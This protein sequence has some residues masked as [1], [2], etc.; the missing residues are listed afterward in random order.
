VE[1][2]VDAQGYEQW[3]DLTFQ[4]DREGIIQLLTGAR[5]YQGPHAVVKELL[6]NAVDASR[7]ARALSR[8]SIPIRVEFSSAK[9]TLSISDGGIGMDRQ[10]I[11]EFL[12]RLGR[13]IYRSDLYQQR[14]MPKQRIDALSE[15]GIGFASCFLVSDHVVVETKQEGQDAYLLDLYDLLGFAAARK[16]RPPAA[17]TTV[18]LHLKESILN[19]I[20]RAVK[21]IGTTCPHMEIPI[22]VC[23]DGEETEVVAQPYCEEDNALLSPFFRSKVTDLVVEHHHFVLETDSV[24][25]CICL[26]CHRK[27][28]LVLP[29]Y[30]D[31]F[32]LAASDR[33]RISQLGF[34][35][36]EPNKLLEN[37]LSKFNVAA[38]RYDLDLRG[39]M[40]LEMDPSR[41]GV[42]GSNH[43]VEV[44]RRLDEYVVSYLC[45][46]H[47]K[48]WA[49]IT[50]ESRFI[51]YREFGH[52]FFTRVMDAIFFKAQKAAIRLADLMFDNM[53]LNTVSKSKGSCDLTWN[54]IRQL[55]APVVFYQRFQFEVDYENHVGSILDAVPRAI[56]VI[57]EPSFPFGSKFQW[58][59]TVKQIHVS[60][61]SQRIPQRCITAA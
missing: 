7:Q 51:V 21:H 11:E 41:T 46:L 59:C 55:S 30:P 58:Y 28:G 48:Y 38:L 49:G 20:E 22:Q 52:M 4:I 2:H 27:D 54:E 25:G 29:G 32:R 26:L 17:G 18:T 43:N 53:P 3:L 24:E 23:V 61:N 60:E 36:P 34:V 12:L 33:R 47:Q 5:I 13:C 19:E 10:D 39:G 35:L 56:V 44:I 6:M 42:L 8:G 37:L 14:Y 16:S 15:F 31:W 40:R 57:E 1:P 50:R 9:S 45:D